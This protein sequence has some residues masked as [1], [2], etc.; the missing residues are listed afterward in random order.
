MGIT[1]IS[2]F[3]LGCVE[4]L[5]EFAPV[6]STAHILISGELLHIGQ[7]P[8]FDVFSIAI[9]SGAILAAIVFFWSVVW[10]HLS[11]IPKLIVGFIPT[12]IAGILLHSVVT[13]LFS[14]TWIIGVALIIGGI[15]FLFLRPI[16]TE[17]EVKDISYTQAFLIGCTQILAFIPG[18]SRSG[19]T[20]IGGTALKMPRSRI[21]TFSFLL[22]IP[23]IL[24]ASVVGLQSLPD[25]SSEQW[26]LLAL[27]TLT[28]FIVALFTI[29]WFIRLLTKKPLSWFGWYRIVVGIL[30]LLILK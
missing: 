15:V 18:V 1:L 25:I 14:H 11:L 28:A 2:S 26:G 5:T 10:G 7:S 12:A 27:G 3:I 23:T 22:G 20:L 30:I 19:A 16:D 21:V 24:G 13:K 9:Q 6:S 29:K 4:G 8:F 17:T